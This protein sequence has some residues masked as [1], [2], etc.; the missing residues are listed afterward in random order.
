MT[1]DRLAESVRLIEVGLPAAPARLSRRRRFLPLGVDVAGDVA[2][3]AFLRRGA[4]ADELEINLLTRQRGSWQLHGGGGG[5]DSLAE[6]VRPRTVAELG[7]YGRVEAGSGVAVGRTWIDAAWLGC[8]PEVTAVEADG[9]VL[10]VPWNHHVVVLCHG[11]GSVALLDAD[12]GV[13]GRLPLRGTRRAR[14]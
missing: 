11:A 13:L 6:I 9:R 12:G 10:P 4:G 3:A 8:V 1:Y 7:G 2:A 5:S 14:G